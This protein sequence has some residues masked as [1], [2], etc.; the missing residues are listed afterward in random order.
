MIQI[1]HKDLDKIALKHYEAMKV[2]RKK[3]N[4]PD[5]IFKE[6]ILAKPQELMSVAQKY[7]KY[8]NEFKNRYKN[9]TNTKNIYNA[10]ELIKKLNIT[11]CPYCNRNTIFNLKHSRKRTSELDHFYP[12]SKYLILSISFYNLIPSCS[13]CNK[14]KS[15]KNNKYINPYDKQYNFNKN[16]KF[17]LK[18]KD[19]TFAYS[20]DGFKL[21]CKADKDISKDEKR[22]AKNN[23]QVFRLNDLYQKH[24]D[25]VLELIQKREIYPDSYIDELYQNYS[26]FNNRE[27]ILR[28]ITGGYVEDKDLGKRPLS[29]LIKD[30]SEELELI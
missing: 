10:Y 26:F 19:V 16:I 11:V 17:D 22:R 9:F 27:D 8:E 25:T 4:I 5:D 15:N 18:I 6:I 28:L 14:F 7:K 3:T 12:K 20:T 29:K 24:K 2:S 1:T 13:A 30:I 21:V 23:I